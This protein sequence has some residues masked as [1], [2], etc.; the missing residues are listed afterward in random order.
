LWFSF[1][2]RLTRGDTICLGA[3]ETRQREGGWVGGWEEGRERQPE[4]GTEGRREEGT[5][6]LSL[7]LGREGWREGK[8]ALS[9]SLVL[10]QLLLSLFSLCL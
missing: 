1:D 9:L 3:Q 8:P 5:P 6:A 2:V 7:S 10:S 4:G